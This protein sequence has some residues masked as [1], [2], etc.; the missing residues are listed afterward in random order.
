[1]LYHSLLS[2]HLFTPHLFTPHLV[3]SLLRIS[4][5]PATSHHTILHFSTSNFTQYL[6]FLS[7]FLEYLA[8]PVSSRMHLS[9]LCGYSSPPSPPSQGWATQATPSTTATTAMPP[10]C[11]AKVCLPRALYSLLLAFLDTPSQAV[12]HNLNEEG[13]KRVQGIAIGNRLGPGIE[14]ASLPELGEGGS[15]STCTNGCHLEPPQAR[16]AEAISRFSLFIFWDSVGI[17]PY[18][19]IHFLELSS[20]RRTFHCTSKYSVVYS[21]VTD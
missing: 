10:P 6:S 11:L 16:N 2:L 19:P 5:H 15:W 21:V 18:R 4:V 20:D 1:M 12:A 9:L 13:N 14:I 17:S 8:L 3:T 7:D